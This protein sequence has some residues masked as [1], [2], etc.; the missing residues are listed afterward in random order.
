MPKP[1]TPITANYD[2]AATILEALMIFDLRNVSRT[3]RMLRRLVKNVVQR[4]LTHILGPF[5]GDM[6]GPFM[7]FLRE[8]RGVITG[9]CA[10]SMVTGMHEHTARDLNIVVPHGGF[11]L[12]HSMLQDTLGFTPI[13]EVAHPA[14]AP[15]IGRFH[16][17]KAKDRIITMAEPQK[18]DS[19][20]HIILNA[21]TTAD[22]IFMTTGGLCVFYP[23][24]LEA[25][26]AIKSHAGRL[27]SYDRKLGTAGELS[28]LE[29]Q[30]DT[31]FLGSSCGDQCPTFWHHVRC[32]QLRLSVDWDQDDSVTNVFHNVDV[33]WR[34][35]T[36]CMNSHCSYN[37]DQMLQYLEGCG[38][39][40]REC[41]VQKKKVSYTLNRG[42]CEISATRN[43]SASTCKLI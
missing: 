6:Q 39:S 25:N 33:E 43:S 38:A 40:H 8:Q 3:C 12:L 31:D 26:I 30:D 9:S 18:Q 23:R 29:V 34:L 11:N 14:L 5:I 37:W 2:I 35:N 15:H 19:V 7:R 13:S 32:Q 42:R 1:T 24:C 4:R 28:D 20:L 10:K 22:M 27:V 41:T 17:Y 36:Y 16:I 21:P